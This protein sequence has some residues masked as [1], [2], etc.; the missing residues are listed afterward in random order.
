AGNLKSEKSQRR[1]PQREWAQYVRLA[2]R[3]LRP[4][5]ALLQL[6]LAALCLIL[7]E[8]VPDVAGLRLVGW[9][10]LILSAALGIFSV[11]VWVVAARLARRRVLALPFRPDGRPLAGGRADGSLQLLDL[12]QEKVSVLVAGGYEPVIRALAFRRGTDGEE[13][14]ILDAAG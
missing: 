13:V 6:I 2:Q 1:D 11:V 9:V 14:A 7:G 8:A 5:A 12:D 10:A 4:S 3:V